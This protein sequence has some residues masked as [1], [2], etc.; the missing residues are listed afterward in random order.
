M[1]TV[2]TKSIDIEIRIFHQRSN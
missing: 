2:D 1:K